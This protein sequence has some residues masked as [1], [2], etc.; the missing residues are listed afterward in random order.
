MLIYTYT[1]SYRVRVYY[2]LAIIQYKNKRNLNNK[3]IN[4]AKVTTPH[5]LIDITV[6][7]ILMLVVTFPLSYIVADKNNRKMFYLQNYIV[8]CHSTDF[9]FL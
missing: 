9:L 5:Y 8:L 4:S 1:V 3:I 2:W 7:L 6:I